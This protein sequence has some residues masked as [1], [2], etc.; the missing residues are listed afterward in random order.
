MKYFENSKYLHSAALS[1]IATVNEVYN[2]IKVWLVRREKLF[3]YIPL[4]GGAPSQSGPPLAIEAA[5]S[6]F[7]GL[8]SV[9]QRQGVNRRWPNQYKCRGSYKLHKKGIYF[10]LLIS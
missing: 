7:S 3:I 8:Q 10:C 5:T 4:T 9:R 6:S 1:R 2:Q